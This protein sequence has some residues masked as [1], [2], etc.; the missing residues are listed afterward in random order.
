MQQEP[1]H[2]SSYFLPT[3]EQGAYHL[4]LSVL[5]AALVLLF[6]DYAHALT[7]SDPL[8]QTICV[9]VNW[10]TGSVGQAVATLGIMVL[11][12]GALMGKVSWGAA[13]TVAVGV[14][15]M[16]GGASMVQI[17]VNVP[18]AETLCTNAGPAIP[19]G[20]IEEVLCNLAAL[21]NSP[22]GRALSTLAIGFLGVSCLMGKLSAGTAIITAV[23]IGVFHGADRIGTVLTTGLTGANWVAFGCV[24]TSM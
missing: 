3:H 9:V 24:P 21:A 18:G 10:F 5:F 12:I 6:P 8:T 20:A 13:V 7:A 23:G 11:G 19:A 22:T 14:A 15:I 17:L 2:F 1:F 16:F 4:T